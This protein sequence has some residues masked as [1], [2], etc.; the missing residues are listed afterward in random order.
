MIFSQ[1]LSGI[2]FMGLATSSL[3]FFRIWRE[4]SDRLF[5]H[6]A[7]AFGLMAAERIP[8]ALFLFLQEPTSW[9]YVFRLA[10]FLVMIK[11]IV[12]KNV[13]RQ[14]VAKGESASKSDIGNVLSGKWRHQ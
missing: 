2:Y 9:V 5:Y 6:F 12:E 1:F 3:L 8:L 11:G 13:Q 4:T 10:G 14:S 7:I